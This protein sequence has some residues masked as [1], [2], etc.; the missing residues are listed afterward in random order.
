MSQPHLVADANTA[1]TDR[2]YP[3]LPPELTQ[4]IVDELPKSDLPAIRLANKQLRGNAASAF[5][6]N[7]AELTI[8]LSR[9][10]LEAV[11]AICA[12]PVFGP[13]VER[14]NFASQRLVAVDNDKLLEYAHEKAA[15]LAGSTFELS[16]QRFVDGPDAETNSVKYAENP[17]G[18][19]PACPTKFALRHV[20]NH[21]EQQELGE[22]SK[23]ELSLTKAF[24]ALKKHGNPVILR[25]TDT[26]DKSALGY[27]TFSQGEEYGLW[28]AARHQT[29]KLLLNAAVRSGIVVDALSMSYNSWYKR[30]SDY[31]PHAREI[32]QSFVPTSR[33]T[34]SK[35]SRNL[36]ALEI[37][38]SKTK[39]HMPVSQSAIL[40]VLRHSLNLEE[41]RLCL[42][43]EIREYESRWLLPDNDRHYNLNWTTAAFENLQT[44]CLRRLDLSYCLLGTGYKN[45]LVHIQ[46]RH[47]ATLR[48]LKISNCEIPEDHYWSEI[49]ASIL[50]PLNFGNLEM[51]EVERLCVREGHESY[52]VC[53]PK[54]VYK[55][56]DSARGLYQLVI[57]LKGLET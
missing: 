11:G 53:S 13:R 28:Q 10:S 48:E 51:I 47:R 16:R 14:I 25:M 44:D 5:A 1:E 32:H 45:P 46:P 17:V 6:A 31:G 18:A 39:A 49:F 2:P 33:R 35:V 29:F 21:K 27:K 23:G 7:F 34:I 52:S 40:T 54:R 55:H 19:P 15:A 50:H 38:F 4:M 30:D 8:F 12:D 9:G 37:S 57:D 43:F 3:H 26:V 36:K 20:A 22:T 42:K 56:D 24:E 41:L